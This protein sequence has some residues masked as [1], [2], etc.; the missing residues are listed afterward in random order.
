MAESVTIRFRITQDEYADGMRALMLGQLTF[1][2][3][4]VLGA[5]TL[6]AGVVTGDTVAKVWGTVVLALAAAS[7]FIV[8]ALRWKQSP[9]LAEQKHTFSEDG[10]LVRAAGNTGRL[11]WGFYRRARE[12]ARVY[13]LLRNRR[14][15]NFL[16]KR[17][18]ASP[19]EEERFR[20]MVA[21]RLRTTWR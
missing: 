7:F 3:G 10:I 4:P 15:A 18:F 1:W 14:Q 20:R 21:E 5:A 2:V 16:P 12:T 13:V 9:Q 17:A 19:E 11:P 8:P 6:V